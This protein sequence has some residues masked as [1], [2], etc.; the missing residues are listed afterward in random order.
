MEPFSRVAAGV[1]VRRS[2]ESHPRAVSISPNCAEA[3]RGCGAVA[4]ARIALIATLLSCGAETA[5]AAVTEGV[6]I[7][8]SNQRPTVA[9]I[10][11]EDTL[12]KVVP[13]LLKRPVEIYSEYLDIE[14][15][16]IE[17]YADVQAEFLRRKYAGRN[18][19]VIVAAAP[20]A[21]KF[22]VGSR[23]RMLPGVPVVHIALPRD[24]LR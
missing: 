8:H 7:I 14:R 5:A 15:T 17:G 10:V 24:Q 18:I 4:A 23:D 3:A 20:D 16:P 13:D 12:R 21:V 22:A 9:A 6:L 2:P 19:R 11:I 1:I